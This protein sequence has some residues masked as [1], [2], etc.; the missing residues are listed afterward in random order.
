MSKTVNLG[1]GYSAE[2]FKGIPDK[3]GNEWEAFLLFNGELA[4]NFEG[5]GM[6]GSA[7]DTIVYLKE[8]VLPRYISDSKIV[9]AKA[10]IL[11]KLLSGIKLK[12]IKE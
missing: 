9:V 11:L 5:S 1:R 8:T 4:D 7:E 10:D 6:F 2:V 12:E 3:D